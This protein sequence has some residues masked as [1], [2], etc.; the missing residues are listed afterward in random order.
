MTL[1][2]PVSRNFSQP[3]V[4]PVSSA[5]NPVP[6]YPASF[7]LDGTGQSNKTLTNTRTST[8]LVWDWEGVLVEAKA[9]E[10][11]LEGGRREENLCPDPRDFSSWS[12]DVGRGDVTVN[13]TTSSDGEQLADLL[14]KNSESSA[15]R[16]KVIAGLGGTVLAVDVK[17]EDASEPNW[18]AFNTLG[19]YTYFDLNNVAIGA[20]GTTDAGIEMLGNGYLRCYTYQDTPST[21]VLGIFLANG[22]VNTSATNWTEGKGVYLDRAAIH[23]VA[24]R[25]N[26]LPPEYIDTDTDY[27]FGVNG[28]KWYANENG[29]TQSGDIITRAAGTALSPVPQILL[30]PSKTNYLYP[31]EP[32][33]AD[34]PV[35]GGGV[36]DAAV[37]LQGLFNG[38]DFDNSGDTMYAYHAYDA[39][40]T[41]GKYWI[42]V[43]VKMADE[44]AP[45]LG[46]TSAEGDFSL[47]LQGAIVS[48]AFVELI[49]S[50]ENLYRVSGYINDPGG[51]SNNHGVIRYAS[52]SGKAFTVSGYMLSTGE[53]LPEYVRT[54]TAAATRDNDLIEVDD[55]DS[56]VDAEEGILLLRMK[57][58]VDLADWSGGFVKGTLDSNRVLTGI[59]AAST[60]GFASFDGVTWATSFS[61]GLAG[62][63]LRVSVVWSTLHDSFSVGYYDPTTDAFVW[64]VTQPFAGWTLGPSYKLSI[65]YLA[66]E[67]FSTSKLRIYKGKPP[68]TTTFA[69]AKTWA[70]EN[71]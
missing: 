21:T 47:I 22:D 57:S 51:A 44:T 40:A 6:Q 18:I 26:T 20:Q 32:E 49:N 28:V 70:E 25:T 45:V 34:L 16:Y 4:R 37:P 52:Q 7:M 27:G 15:Y 65:A 23:N 53:G 11:V 39:S 10:I 3:M 31:S 71:A 19:S 13:V 63:E 35:Q 69:E 5:Q 56:I 50:T 41:S 36:T 12:T 24:G 9:G 29:A 54:T 67:A 55:W 48:A 17:V 14:S 62:E 64:G 66:D 42:S 68:G 1:H 58:E 8:A 61:G 46:L 59:G 30:Q 38:V 33:L 60:P 2:T 43:F